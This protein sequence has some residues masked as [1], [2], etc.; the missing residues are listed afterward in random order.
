MPEPSD[1]ADPA[2][3]SPTR[4]DRL[5]GVLLGTAL[6]DALGLPCEG[7]PARRIAARFDG[8][9]RFHLFGRTG[10]VSDDT[11]QAALIAASL[12]AHPDDPDAA[13]RSFRRGLL[14]WFFRLPFG[15]GFGTLRACLR[16]ALGF[17]ES[18]IR[19]AGNGAAM[20]AGIVGV[21]FADDTRI[22]R[23]LGRRFATVTHTD[24][25]AVEGALFVAELAALCA[26]A[27][28]CADR[29][30]LCRDAL[31]VVENEELATA[32]DRA[33]ELSLQGNVTVL[34]AAAM[35]GTSGFVIQSVPFSTFVFLRHGDTPRQAIVETILAGGDTDTNGA[36]V[37]AWAGVLHG[38][39]AL[40]KDLIDR[41]QDGPFG[42]THLRRL[43][44]ALE[45]GKPVRI[46]YNPVVA[47]LRNLLLYPVVLAHGFRRLVPFP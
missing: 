38:S 25:R 28:P 12:A 2:T 24:P 6:G 18:G 40:P 7:M 35:L 45:N 5:E 42:P 15:I 19:S 9:T 39:G 1:A 27:K 10:F 3:S 32:V 21:V 26:L 43:A 29:V 46:R 13:L 11:E 41:I 36:I 34:D 20:R 44:A 8:F 33:V 30:G 37:G 14:G 23:E 31:C 4:L 17:R 47:F 22:R 16:L